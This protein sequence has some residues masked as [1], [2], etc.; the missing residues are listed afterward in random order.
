MCHHKLIVQIVEPSFFF[1]RIYSWRK[2]PSKLHLLLK[3]S[4][5]FLDRREFPKSF[6]RQKNSIK[7]DLHK[8]HPDG[9][10]FYF[11][12]FIF[13]YFFF[14]ILF[15]FILFYFIYLTF[16]FFLFFLFLRFYCE[17]IFQKKII[18]PL[19]GN[20]VGNSFLSLISMRS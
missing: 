1:C 10:R 9:I 20:F 8:P 7:L 2:W 12:Y 17:V 13:I 14:F 15:Y 6:Q 3:W 5:T 11:I 4:L 16:C 18:V 19:K